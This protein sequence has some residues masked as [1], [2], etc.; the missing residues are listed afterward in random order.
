ML[1]DDSAHTHR[2]ADANTIRAMPR[3]DF[4]MPH[5]ERADIRVLRMRPREGAE[6]MEGTCFLGLL[7][8]LA[9]VAVVVV[10]ASTSVTETVAASPKRQR[11]HTL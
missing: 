6:M 5:T 8:L 2:E 9:A 4:H 1:N 10:V 11:R 7:S 3:Y